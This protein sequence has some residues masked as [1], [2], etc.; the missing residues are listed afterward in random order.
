[1]QTNSSPSSPIWE[2]AKWLGQITAFIGAISV[3]VLGII[4]RKRRSVEKSENTQREASSKVDLA[5]ASD[6]YA[7]LGIALWDELD[8]MHRDARILEARLHYQTTMETI[9]RN[10][11]HRM[12]NAYQAAIMVI[13]EREEMLRCI[14]AKLKADGVD[15]EI[16]IGFTPF[17][18]RTQEEIFGPE[19]LPLPPEFEKS[20]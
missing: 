18:I 2:A 4:N 5:S 13:M 9:A 10:R 6:K 15:L 19:D 12:T 16:E 17:P 20:Q 11:T 8:V 7:R 1:M 3:V 14:A